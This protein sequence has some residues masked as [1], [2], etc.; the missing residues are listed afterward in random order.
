MKRILLTL[1]VLSTATFGI[2]DTPKIES[3]SLE[4]AKLTDAVHLISMASGLPVVCTP[5]AA[6]KEVTLF[7]SNLPFEAALQA[8]CRAHG[9]WMNHS[10]EGV[11]IISTLE[12]HLSSQAVFSGDFMESVIVKYP[13][14]YDVGDTLKGLFRD[15][16]VWERPDENDSDPV[17]AI[18][19]ALERMDTLSSRSQLDITDENSSSSSSRSSSRS[20]SSR[21]S[22]SHNSTDYSNGEELEQLQTM[23]QREDYVRSRLQQQSAAGAATAPMTALIYLSALPEVNTL[24]VRSSDRDAVQLVRRAIAEMD[25]PRGQVL[26]RVSVLSLTLDDSLETGVEWLFEEGDTSGGFANGLIQS[27]SENSADYITGQTIIGQVSEKLQTRITALAQKGNTRELASPTLLV[28]DN[29]AA[30]V[31]IG[32]NVK[33][34]D[35]ITVTPTY[36]NETGLVTGYTT[37][38]ELEERGHR[39]LPAH[40]AARSC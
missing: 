14:V 12:Q 8:M 24:L 10:P 18:E 7:V 15:R 40:H 9:L 36:N 31:F 20:S 35:Q 30:N 2:A 37:E 39:N 34:L 29:E 33:L 17:E 38:A 13:S 28:A 25:K 19:R 23:Q 1:M 32:K 22:S 3:F 21:S 16:I 5:E 11:V 6:Q 4:N 26:L 27:L